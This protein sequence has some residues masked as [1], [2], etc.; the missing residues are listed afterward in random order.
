VTRRPARIAIVGGGAMGSI[1][2]SLLSGGGHDV[3]LIDVW[4]EHVDAVRR[5]GLRVDG[6]GDRQR[7][8]T[9]S[10]TTST[11]DIGQ[12]DLVL[13]AVKAFHTAQA[14]ASVGRLLTPGGI[15]LT[16][17]NGIGNAERLAAMLPDARVAIGVPGHG[18]TLLRPG[19]VAHRVAAPTELG[20]LRPDAADDPASVA[21]L[22][23]R[24]GLET[25]AT[26]DVRALLWAHVAVVAGVNAIAALCRI[27]NYEV[28]TLPDAARLSE[29]AV[30]E[31]VAVATAAGVEL[32][33]DDPVA[34]A[35][36]VYL[37]NGPAHL[38][39]M[40]VDVL[41]ERR[42]EIDA[43]NGAVVEYGRQ[44]GIPTPVNEALTLAI[45]TVEQTSG[46]RAQLTEKSEASPK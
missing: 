16:M 46:R 17:Q 40:T 29:L 1:Y 27:P 4:R 14:G 18:G 2:A 7:V 33:W 19:H 26:H 30:R 35:R 37:A 38:S 24:A 12:F 32:R 28:A 36:A 42:T 31:V 10:A 22:L 43:L 6:P 45:K 34:A 15:V 25:R 20:W 44:L 11:E 9:I 8:V 39:S 23:T 13:V 41:R 21:E 5:H 3:W